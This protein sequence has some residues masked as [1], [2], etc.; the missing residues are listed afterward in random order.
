MLEYSPTGAISI[1]SSGTNTFAGT[2]GAGVLFS[3]DNGFTWYAMNNGLPKDNYGIYPNINSIIIYGSYI[4]LGTSNANNPNFYGGVYF[5]TINGSSWTPVNYA[6]LNV[7]SL[8]ASGINIFAGTERGVYLSTNNGTSWSAENTGLPTYPNDDIWS[9]ATSG[10]NIFAGGLWGGL[11]FSNDNGTIWSV[12]SPE[13]HNNN[14]NNISSLAINSSYI[15]ASTTTSP[16]YGTGIWKCLLSDI[17]TGVNEIQIIKS[18]LQ[19]KI[20]P[21]PTSD[22]INVYLSNCKNENINAEIYDVLGNLVY[23]ESFELHTSDIIHQINISNLND[24]VYIIKFQT[25]DQ[26]ETQ[27]I[28]VKH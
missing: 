7:N 2:D 12:V 26:T 1:T 9:L 23:S 20:Y 16:N 3:P 19:I 13:L 22:F 28:I 6:L 14:N 25:K 18:E 24:G 11:F 10:L 15:F 17:L 8:T 5:S 27:K 4:F 21:N